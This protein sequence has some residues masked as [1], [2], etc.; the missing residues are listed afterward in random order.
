MDRYTFQEFENVSYEEWKQ[1]A[2]KTLKGTAFDSIFT[3]MYEN[4]TLKPLYTKEDIQSA[5][6]TQAVSLF[7]VY[8]DTIIAQELAGN[9]LDET[10]QKVLQAIGHGQSVLHVLLDEATR[11]G[12]DSDMALPNK[13]L[14]AGVSINC[15]SDFEHVLQGVPL[16]RCSFLLYTGYWAMPML[17]IAAVYSK[18]SGLSF[19]GT[20]GADPLGCLA[21]EGYIPFTLQQSFDAIAGTVKWTKQHMPKVRTIFVRTDGYHNAGANAVQELAAALATAVQYVREGIKRGITADD[22]CRQMTFSFSVGTQLFMEIAKLRAIRVLWKKTAENFG[23]KETTIHLHTRTS[24]RTKT[25]YDHHVNLLRAT[26][27]AFSAIVGGA[28]TLHVSTYN[29]AYSISEENSERWARN[30]Q[31]ILCGESYLSK[32]SDPASGSYYVEALTEQLAEKAWKLFQEIEAKGGMSVSLQQGWLQTSIAET[33]KRRYRNITALEQKIVGT[34]VYIKQDELRPSGESR[35]IVEKVQR[36]IS[37]MITYKEQRLLKECMRQDLP[38]HHEQTLNELVHAGSIGTTIG[39]MTALFTGA[40]ENIVPIRSMRD[41][42]PFEKLRG[43]TEKYVNRTGIRPHALL[44]QIAAEAKGKGL[45]SL[46]KTMLEACGYHVSTGQDTAE[47]AVL[48]RAETAAL[49]LEGDLGTVKEAI[50]NIVQSGYSRHIFI[51]GQLSEEEKQLLAENGV[52]DFLQ[53]A[54]EVL[55]LLY[56]LQNQLE[57]MV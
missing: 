42:E 46:V 14:Q 47:I 21:E 56:D 9:S 25:L 1:L 49:F 3:D 37:E 53:E 38:L 51:I 55:P 7:P 19:S 44:M 22:I 30:I 52:S 31:H 16:E 17:A 24:K 6:F 15:L 2:E 11:Q 36:R 8:R 4:I 45:S 54:G 32:V 10:N 39:E 23:A 28:D 43:A 48:T 5:R 57:V 29:E 18:Q 33:A 26:T 50:T 12:K 35:Q 34:N 40:G 13:V 41:A 27:E 20:I